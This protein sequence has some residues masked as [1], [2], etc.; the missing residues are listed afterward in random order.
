[1][2][3]LLAPVGTAISGVA[4]AVNRA[5]LILAIVLGGWGIVAQNL[6]QMGVP[7]K[8]TSAAFGVLSLI[9]VDFDQI[10]AL[11][12]VL[13]AAPPKTA[14]TTVA[15]GPH[16][17]HFTAEEVVAALGLP[18]VAAT[19]APPPFPATAWTAPEPPALP[20]PAAPEPPAV[21]VVP[22]APSPA[23]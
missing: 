1:M 12:A 19:V 15:P 9:A 2:P 23:P 17:E 10:K 3:S 20:S 18:P 5:R 14:V 16:H 6:Q 7:L 4:A 8:A 11:F 21:P 13:F 22:S